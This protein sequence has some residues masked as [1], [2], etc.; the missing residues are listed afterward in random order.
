MVRPLHSELHIY[1]TVLQ[2]YAPSASHRQSWTEALEFC[3]AM[4]ADLVSIHSQL[5]NSVVY[6][7]TRIR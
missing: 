6:S 3:K 5:E 1:N 4:N 7:V 2:A